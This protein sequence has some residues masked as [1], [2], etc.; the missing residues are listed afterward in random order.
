MPL[1]YKKNFPN[2]W[3]EEKIL[4]CVTEI[5]TNP[6][7]RWQQITGQDHSL[8]RPHKF[9]A[10]GEWDGKKIRVVLEPCDRGILTAYPLG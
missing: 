6:K 7:I 9:I 5:A 10:D 8:Y 3:N 4:N 2:D 1:S